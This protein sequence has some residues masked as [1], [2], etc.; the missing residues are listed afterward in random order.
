MAHMTPDN[1]HCFSPGMRAETALYEAPQS[2]VS[3]DF[4]V[5]HSVRYLEG[6]R[7]AE[8]EGRTHSSYTGITASFAGFTSILCWGD[9]NGNKQ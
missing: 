5:Y 2:Q 8:G 4:F 3:D 9:T 1:S 6:E 7:A